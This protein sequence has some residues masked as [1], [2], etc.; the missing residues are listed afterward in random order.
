MYKYTEILGLKTRFTKE[1]DGNAVL[2]L[3]GWGGNVDSFKIISDKLRCCK[4]SLDLWGQGESEAPEGWTIERYADAIYLFLK[5]L[6]ISNVTIVAHSFGCRVAVAFAAKYLHNINGLVLLSAA[7]FRF[8]SVKR[9]F[10]IANYKF[11]KMLVKHNL[12]KNRLDRYG[13]E[14]YKILNSKMKKE[15]N[16][17]VKEDLS[18]YAKRIKCKTLLIWGDRD[19]ETPLKYMKRYNKLIKNSKCIVIS[20]N[21]YAY[22]NSSFF[23]AIKIQNFIN[24]L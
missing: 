9:L 17:I 23:I 14:D 13:S 24:V 18:K 11:K 15:F 10:K 20:G 7:G 3:H 8:F 1:D 16:L 19:C 6:K 22:L 2:F 4:I 12:I 21:H 5:Y